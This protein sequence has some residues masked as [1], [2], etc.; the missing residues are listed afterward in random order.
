MKPFLPLALLTVMVTSG[1]GNELALVQT[2]PLPPARVAALVERAHAALQG[3]RDRLPRRG[4][5]EA[6]TRD[7]AAGPTDDAEVASGERAASRAAAAAEER[8]A[9]KDGKP[10]LSPERVAKMK[11]RVAANRAARAAER[12]SASGTAAEPTVDYGQP[13]DQPASYDE[14]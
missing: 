11:A 12:S 10:A 2:E 13:A 3:E 8:A 9:R 6:A 1:C 4:R 5:V 7:L 14:G